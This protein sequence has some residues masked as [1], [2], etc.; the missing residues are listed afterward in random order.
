MDIE[1]HEG[2][3]GRIGLRAGDSGGHEI[4]QTSR[5]GHD[6]RAD[7]GGRNLL[8]EGGMGHRVELVADQ[9]DLA[10]TTLLA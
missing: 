8:G 9:G 4:H 7:H 5:Q 10:D 3:A 1:R 6:R 2:L